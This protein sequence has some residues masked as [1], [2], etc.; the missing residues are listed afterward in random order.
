MNKKN[1]GE[2]FV[3]DHY[4]NAK[5]CAETDTRG[6]SVLKGEGGNNNYGNFTCTG[7]EFFLIELRPAV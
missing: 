6:N 7:L 5:Y 1:S 3:K 2:C 4:D